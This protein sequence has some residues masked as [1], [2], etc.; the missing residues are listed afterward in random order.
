MGKVVNG[1]DTE[2]FQETV[3]AIKKDPSLA[4]AEF[5]ATNQWDE[6]GHNQVCIQSY[7]LAGA[8]QQ[9]RSKPFQ[10]DADEPPALLGQD[11]GANPVEYLLTAL[12]SCMTTSMVYHAAANGLPIESMESK[13][14]GELDLRGFLDLDPSIPK[15][16][17]KIRATFKVKSSASE[18]QLDHFY[19]F[20]PVYSMVSP[21]VPI[22]V[23]I[24]KE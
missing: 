13:F 8:E 7:Y 1:V 21:T 9:T 16:Y 4:Q 2:A 6:A 17:S 20:S 23:T 15:G 3:E 10:F 24:I 5:R 19:H 18:E 22:E 12:S 14:E 11:S